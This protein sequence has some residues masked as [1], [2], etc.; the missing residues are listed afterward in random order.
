MNFNKVYENVTEQFQNK[1]TCYVKYI[2]SKEKISPR[3]FSTFL[4]LFGI[5]LLGFSTASLKSY[6]Y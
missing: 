1:K 4:T 6:L 2:H 5:P 3:G